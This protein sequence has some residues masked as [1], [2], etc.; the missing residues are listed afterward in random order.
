MQTLHDNHDGAVSFVIEGGAER[1]DVEFPHASTFCLGQSVERLDGIIDHDQIPAAT[2]DRAANARGK[3]VPMHA[4]DEFM[5]ALNR[6]SRLQGREQ[7]PIPSALDHTAS[8]DRELARQLVGIGHGNDPLCRIAS[9][10][11]GG[12][13]NGHRDRFHRARRDIDNE[14]FDL[15]PRH[16]REL[17]ANMIDVPIVPIDLFGL[18]SPEHA[19]DETKQ[20]LPVQ[21]ARDAVDL[22]HWPPPDRP[23]LTPH[24]PFLLPRKFSSAKRP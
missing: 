20:V 18:E 24:L 17:P 10:Y 11:P 1:A 21:S 8:I 19:L 23:E 2:K 14:A 6:R 9:Q 5:A 12:E 16:T 22:S 7:L 4:G 3:P 15:A 13:A